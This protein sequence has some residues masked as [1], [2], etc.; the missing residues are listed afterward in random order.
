VSA[1]TNLIVGDT[2]YFDD[3]FL[4]DRTWVAPDAT[5]SN[6]GAGFPGT[7]GVPSLTASADPAFGAQLAI[8]VGSSVSGWTIA[9]LLIG[10]DAAS[11][12]TNDGGTLLVDFSVLLAFALAPGG[13][14]LPVEIPI[15]PALCGESAFLQS[16]ELDPGAQ[17]GLSFSAGLELDFGQ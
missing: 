9:F 1:A 16:I 12:P 5:W 7:L 17:F 14:A 4:D 2:N 8:D 10:A 3:V 13:Y 15:D 11:V 6:Y